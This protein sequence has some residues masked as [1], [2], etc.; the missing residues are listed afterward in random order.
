MTT[1]CEIR[2][3]L[4]GEGVGLEEAHI[5]LEWVLDTLGCVS[6]TRVRVSD[7]LEWVLDS[8][9]CVS[10]TWVRVSDPLEWV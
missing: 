6:D 1:F 4:R 9:G 8:L 7:P 3:V 2:V 10:D 5:P